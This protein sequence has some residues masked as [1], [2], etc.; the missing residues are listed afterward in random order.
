VSAG[1]CIAVERLL[2]EVGHD[3]A[4][5]DGE[6]DIELL[7]GTPAAAGGAAIAGIVC[8]RP[9]WPSTP[10]PPPRCAAPRPAGTLRLPKTLDAAKT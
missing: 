5:G 6:S 4:L 9:P 10:F 3:P 7:C 1:P 2:R 8:Q